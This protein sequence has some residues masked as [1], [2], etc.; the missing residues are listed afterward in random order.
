[1]SG[2]LAVLG[3]KQ[4][5]DSDRNGQTPKGLLKGENKQKQNE[6]LRDVFKKWS[7]N[8]ATT[9]EILGLFQAWGTYCYGLSQ[10]LFHQCP[11]GFSIL[12]FC[13]SH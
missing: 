5:G 9:A 8:N 11:L 3:A 6:C 13:L 2:I 10:V 7:G 1:M 12:C 4:R